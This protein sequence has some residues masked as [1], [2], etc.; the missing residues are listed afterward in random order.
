MHY[1]VARRVRQNES[2]V[3]ASDDQYGF[4]RRLAR[5]DRSESLADVACVI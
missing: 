3:S 5:L 2:T 4:P 1:K